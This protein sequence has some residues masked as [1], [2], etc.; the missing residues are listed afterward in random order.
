MRKMGILAFGAFILLI[1]TACAGGPDIR[2]SDSEGNLKILNQSGVELAVY[3]NTLY[4]KTFK[5]GEQLTIMIDN[6][7]AIGT[8]VDVECF[9]RNKLTNPA[10]YPT[11]QDA[12]YYSFTKRVMP[13]GHPEPVP[14]ICIRAL[15]D[16]ELSNNA[17]INS[18]LV[19]F[20]YN[21]FPRIDST[22]SVFTGSV[23]NQNPIVRLKTDR[24]CSC[25]CLWVSSQ[26]L[27]NTRS[28][29]ELF[30]GKPIL[31]MRIREMTKGFLCKSRPI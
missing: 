3:V 1:C 16:E 14:L 21:D 31:K 9:Y 8:V 15:S 13:L 23:S 28:A 7:E 19:E 11:N 27:W 24:L 2:S 30:N 18:V 26:F 12:R 17:G 20:S 22:V 10:N 29:A 6:A 4:K 5:T 25:R